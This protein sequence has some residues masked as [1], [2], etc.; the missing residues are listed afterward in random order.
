MFNVGDRVILDSGTGFAGEV[1]TIKLVFSFSTIY[2]VELDKN[3]RNVSVLFNQ[4]IAIPKQDKLTSKF[5]EI[6]LS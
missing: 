4:V 2:L 5:K 1:A 6:L 3:G